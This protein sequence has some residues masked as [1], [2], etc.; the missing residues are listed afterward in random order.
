M[1]RIYFSYS[2]IVQIYHLFACAFAF[3][4]DCCWNAS[5]ATNQNHACSRGRFEI[6]PLSFS[7]LLTLSLLFLISILGTIVQ[8]PRAIN[9]MTWSDFETLLTLLFIIFFFLFFCCCYFA[10]TFADVQ[11]TNMNIYSF[12]VRVTL[13]VSANVQMSACGMNGI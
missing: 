1:Q 3:D 10:S 13:A 9:S 2:I 5:T 8:F 7:I 12:R 11:V 6:I 4:V